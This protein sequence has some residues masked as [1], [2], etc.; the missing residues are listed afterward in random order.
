MKRAAAATLA[1]LL[2]AGC[3][4]G[5]P[6]S[7]AGRSNSFCGDALTTIAKLKPPTD[8]RSQMQY[9]IDRYSAVEKT[10]S[11]LTDSSVPGGSA[12]QHLRER[13]L[14]P[15]RTSLA[16]GRAVLERLQEA[17]SAG[18]RPAAAKAF[19][20]ASAVGIS[21]VDAALLETLGLTRCATLFTPSSP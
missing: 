2:L 21:G 20:A 6:T 17:V 7:Y 12:G 10:V 13:W 18:D 8:P 19:E 4:V 11:E 1:A 16:D 9:A 15:A 3:A 5:R 14:R